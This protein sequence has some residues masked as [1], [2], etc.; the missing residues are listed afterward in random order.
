MDNS[1]NILFVDD[2]SRLLRGLQR[3]LGSQAGFSLYFAEKGAN[4]FDIIRNNKIDF[5]VSG[6]K[7]GDMS[8]DMLLEKVK[9]INPGSIR[10]MFSGEDFHCSDNS[11]S[12]GSGSV[13]RYINRPCDSD[14]MFRI[15]QNMGKRWAYV[16]V[17]YR[18]KVARAVP[19]ALLPETIDFV[20]E[21][22]D[23]NVNNEQLIQLLASDPGFIC[24]AIYKHR[25]RMEHMRFSSLPDMVSQLLQ[26]GSV[27]H[28]GD[29]NS[30]VLR[31]YTDSGLIRY[32]RHIFSH[33]LA[34]ANLAFDIAMGIVG[35]NSVLV[36]QTLLAG[37]LHD[38]GKL[39]L[40][41]QYLQQVQAVSQNAVFDDIVA[42]NNEQKL[43]GIDHCQFG[44]MLCSLW[45]LP[46]AVSDAIADHHDKR[47]SKQENDLGTILKDVHSR[48]TEGAC[49]CV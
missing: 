26:E 44:G 16:P 25:R 33:S 10:V 49:V 13:H 11:D 41:E 36:S 47:K 17:A 8:G 29:M 3:V 34:V 12:T 24:W 15:L 5:V 32:Q 9:A 14:G 45:G 48:I 42:L 4:A 23:L 39:I 38:I 1:Q 6:L 22:D 7:V 27:L 28:N 37:L 35:G 18:A 21:R 46:D 20:T 19:P 31:R 2:D 43:F 40:A 30:Q